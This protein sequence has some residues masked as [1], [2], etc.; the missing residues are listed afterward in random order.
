MSNLLEKIEGEEDNST[1]TI[2]A[3][4]SNNVSNTSEPDKASDEIKPEIKPLLKIKPVDHLVDKTRLNRASNSP[5]KSMAESSWNIVQDPLQQ[6]PGNRKDVTYATPIPPGTRLLASTIKHTTTA[7][8][9]LPPG[10]YKIKKGSEEFVMVV[11]KDNEALEASQNKLTTNIS[12]QAQNMN[13]MQGTLTSTGWRFNDSVSTSKPL[14]AVSSG[15]RFMNLTGKMLPVS[16]QLQLQRG[17]IVSSQTSNAGMFKINSVVA[18]T[19]GG[20]QIASGRLAWTGR[21]GVGNPTAP[22]RLVRIAPA[23]SSASGTSAASLTTQVS[24]VQSNIVSFLCYRQSKTLFY[25]F[26]IYT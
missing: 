14:T 21:M 8:T 24:S 1:N 12:T 3:A 19:A 16:Q 15:S 5:E 23:F 9:P 25:Y 18:S 6:S 7:E 11:K 13:L 26:V 4:T 22:P 10:V 20:S 2:E 17:G